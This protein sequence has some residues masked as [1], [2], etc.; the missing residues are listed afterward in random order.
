MA[1]KNYTILA[2]KKSR[3]KIDKTA[4]KNWSRFV[5]NAILQFHPVCAIIISEREKKTKEKEIQ[6]MSIEY[7]E[8][9]A[10]EYEEMLQYEEELLMDADWEAS[11]GHLWD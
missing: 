8:I 6:I 4:Q 9:H 11:G 1:P 5:Q 2:P 10:A 7:Y 3:R